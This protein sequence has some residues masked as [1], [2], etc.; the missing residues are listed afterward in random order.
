[1]GPK[2]MGCSCGKTAKYVRHLKFNHYD[3]D[4]W[5]CSSCGEEYYNPEKAQKILLIN[6]LRKHNF[7]IKLSQ[8]RSNLIIRVPK[9][10]GDAL[11]LHKGEEVEFGLRGDE[12]VIKPKAG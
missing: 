8:I 12:I 2:D 4:G 5:K 10:V 9:L 6:K 11:N 7:H 1:M 3:I